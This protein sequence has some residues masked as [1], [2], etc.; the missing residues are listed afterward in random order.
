MNCFRE[1]T[2]MTNETQHLV[3]VVVLL[4]VHGKQLGHVGTVSKPKHTIPGQV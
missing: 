3:V 1:S 4:Y 2:K